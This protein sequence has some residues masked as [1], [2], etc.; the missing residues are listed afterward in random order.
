MSAL[1]GVLIVDLTHVV[2]GP[3]ATKTLRDLGARVIKVEQVGG[4]FARSLRPRGAY[5][6]ALNGGKESITLQLGPNG[7][8]EDRRILESMLSHADVLV[9]NFRPG[10]M[11]SLGYGWDA[12]HARFPHLI[13]ASVSGFGQTG[14]CSHRKAV[15]TII[16]GMSGFIASTGFEETPVKVGTTVSDLLAGVYCATGVL[17]ALL[18]RHSDGVGSHV[19]IAMLDTSFAFHTREF[20]NYQVHGSEPERHGNVSPVG[21]YPFDVFECSRGQHFAVAIMTNHNFRAFCEVI[22]AAHLVHDERFLE[23]DN[24][25]ANREVLRAAIAKCVKL[26]DRDELL[27]EFWT[28]RGSASFAVGPVNGFADLINDEQLKHRGMLQNVESGRRMVVGNPI[29]IS[30][31]FEKGTSPIAPGLNEHGAQLRLEFGG[32]QSR[33]QTSKL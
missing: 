20:T 11:D 33:K 9:E 27:E 3:M 16:Q 19:D 23:N 30:G 13:V 17:A 22:G 4:D 25:W 10:V 31:M 18:R 7:V 1:Q 29:K 21:I 8:L 28:L 5:F 32:F 2:A 15:D 12:L 14:P 26:R 24:R 6:D